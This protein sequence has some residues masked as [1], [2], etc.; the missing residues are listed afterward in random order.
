MIRARDRHWIFVPTSNQC[1][2]KRPSNDV[3]LMKPLRTMVRQA[4]RLRLPRAAGIILIVLGKTAGSSG[5]GAEGQQDVG[6]RHQTSEPPS[7]TRMLGHRGARP[8]TEVR[9]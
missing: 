9:E 3:V 1:A 2:R 5:D 4:Q 6:N 7:E 8:E